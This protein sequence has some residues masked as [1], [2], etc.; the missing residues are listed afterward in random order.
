MIN[1]AK[2]ARTVGVIVGA[3]ASIA[4]LGTVAALYR[5]LPRTRGTVRL[6]GLHHRVEILRDC[7]G[8]P[9]IYATNND[10][11]FFA[12]GYVHAQDRLWQMEMN[13]RT[14]HGQLAELF[15]AR[16]LDADRFVR[17]L[18]FSRTTH[19]EIERLDAD[20]RAVVDAYVCGVNTFLETRKS[21]LPLEFTLLRQRPRP[22]DAVDVLVWSRVVS[23]SL[24]SDWKAKLLH[25][26]MVAHLGEERTRELM[27]DYSN[28]SPLTVP[29]GV[30]YSPTI[31][32]KALQAAA[33]TA[34]FL[35]SDA[36][37]QGSNGWVVSG[38]RSTTGFPLLANDTHLNLTLPSI[39]YEAHLEGGDY[40]VTGITFPGIPG[41][42]I[43]HNEQIAWGVTNGLIDVQDLYIERFHPN[44]PLLYA[45]NDDWEQAELVREEIAVRGQ[46]EPVVEEVRITRH[47][48]IITSVATPADSPLAPNEELAFRWT[49]LDPGNVFRAALKLN[50][51][52][53]WY[54]FRAA[55]VDW[56][57]TPQNFIYADVEGN[58]GYALSG[59]V[60]L[61]AQ[62]DGRLPVP[63]WEGSYEWIGTIPNEAMP[64]AY[65]PPEGVLVTANNRIADHTYPYCASLRGDWINSY[66]A[67]RIHEML[68]TRPQHDVQSFSRMQQDQ[69]SLPG[70]ELARIVGDL[71]LQ[72]VLQAQVRDLLAAWDGELTAE[73]LGGTI[74]TT[75]RYHLYRCVYAEVEHLWSGGLGRGV[76]TTL[77][78][79]Y[80][81]FRGL[82]RI[83]NR[84]AEAHRN[85][86][87]DEPADAWLGTERTWT[88]VLQQAL[89]RSVDELSQRLGNDPQQWQYGRIHRLK[90]SHPLGR[91]PLLAPLLN[92]GPWKTGGDMDT[93]CMGYLPHDP[94]A[95]PFYVAPSCRQI[96]DT[97]NWDASLSVLASGQSGHPASPHYCDMA[98]LWRSGDYHPMLWSKEHVRQYEVARLVLEPADT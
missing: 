42:L 82:E 98:S 77:A 36:G 63:G 86:Q 94:V 33:A 68:A 59:R 25:A 35:Q 46:K 97:S 16:A 29:A 27:P 51:A 47:G 76:L 45:W 5:P 70:L 96:F 30:T 60:P 57:T 37:P 48:P 21:A 34:P 90:L 84:L 87:M 10:D 43:G 19:R 91:I 18:G 7:W 26:R 58:Y 95:L 74:Y 89:A 14:A 22:W 72:D 4:G 6:A 65:N 61:R 12:Q 31:G 78:A 28:A 11:L 2:V 9:H 49:A 67:M 83:L 80:Y 71:P 75:L 39:W 24:S 3:A 53:D 56:N 54:D 85:G 23:L 55:L 88:G 79:H 1:L 17:V 41:V 73:S 52:R 13:R 62:G 64:A 8:V 20:S 93:V 69:R 15:G 92:R 81:D 66:R 44:D 40:R 38:E 50:R 32:Q